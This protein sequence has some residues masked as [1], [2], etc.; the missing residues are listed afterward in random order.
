MYLLEIDVGF[1]NKRNDCEKKRVCII[2]TGWDKK[3]NGTK[4]RVTQ[5]WTE[6]TLQTQCRVEAMGF[7]YIYI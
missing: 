1:M 7:I 3:N 2:S 4:E 6:M 5:I